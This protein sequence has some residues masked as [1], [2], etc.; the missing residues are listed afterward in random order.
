MEIARIRGD[1]S[2]DF[3]IAVV[4]SKPYHFVHQADVS[5]WSL[6]S[7]HGMQCIAAVWF[8]GARS[9]DIQTV[10]FIGISLAA[11]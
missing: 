8:I 2:I 11:E 7:Q 9:Y 3:D 6:I 1:D 4:E 10:F 5:T